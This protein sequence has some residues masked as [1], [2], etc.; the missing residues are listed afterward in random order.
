MTF[1]GL[2]QEIPVTD[3]IILR[4]LR[5]ES[6][7]TIFQAVDRNRHVLREW[8]PFVDNTWKAADTEIFIKSVLQAK[9]AKPDL[10]YE[11]HYYNDFAGLIALKE[12]DSWNKKTELGYW[13]IPEFQGKGIMIHSCATLVNLAFEQLGMHRIQIK[14]GVG[15]ARSSVIPEKLGFKFEG[16]E[17]NGERFNDRYIDLE[18]YS[19]LKNDK[20]AADLF[21]YS[22]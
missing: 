6:Y 15:N 22:L 19:L 8:L 11:I 12:I 5:Q 13:L 9:G 3:G 7:N 18:V 4:K 14:V 17:R 10:V 1:A 16:I 21:A 2:Q 20:T